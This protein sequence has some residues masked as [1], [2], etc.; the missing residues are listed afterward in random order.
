MS[1]S[2]QIESVCAD[3]YRAVH[4]RCFAH[5]LILERKAANIL[6]DYAGR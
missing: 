2:Q 1:C 6:S 4:S 3:Y 5:M